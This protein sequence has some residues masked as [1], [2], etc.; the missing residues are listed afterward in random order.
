MTTRVIE[1]EMDRQATIRLLE[2][3]KL[4]CTVTFTKG[5]PRSPEQNRLQRLWV[6]EAAEQ[7]QDET[8]EEK[9]AYCKLHYGIPILRAESDEYCEAYDKYIR[10]LTYEAKLAM[11]AVPLDYPVTRLMTSKQKKQYLDEMWQHFKGLG[12][13]LTDP[14]ELK[15]GTRRSA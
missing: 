6:N 9:R 2:S 5:K 14:E 15:T 3:R 13:Q 7:L 12:V 11:M 8:A 4:P 1:N 10:P